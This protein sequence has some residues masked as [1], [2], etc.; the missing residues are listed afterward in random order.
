M[1]FTRKEI[2]MIEKA[3]LLVK[4]NKKLTPYYNIVFLFV[5]TILLLLVFNQI[6]FNEFIYMA[7]PAFF[8]AVIR[9]QLYHKPRYDELVM[10]LSA[11]KANHKKTMDDLSKAIN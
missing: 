8:I 7:I 1:D 5:T 3:E 4:Q 10:I 2:K 9:P 11:K 6:T